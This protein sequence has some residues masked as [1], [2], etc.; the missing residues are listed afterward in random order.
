MQTPEARQ[1]FLHLFQQL[2]QRPVRQLAWACFGPSLIQHW[3]EGIS[4]RINPL[5]AW[6]CNWLKQLDQ[7]PSPLLHCLQALKNARLGFL[8][9]AYWQFYLEQ[10]PNVELLASNHQIH[11]QGKTLGAFDLLFIDEQQQAVHLEL[12]L[13]FYLGVSGSPSCSSSNF[14]CWLGPGQQDTLSSKYHHLSQQQLQLSQHSAAIDYLNQLGITQPPKK[15]AWMQGVLFQ[16]LGPRL[17]RADNITPHADQGLWCH[18]EQLHAWLHN[19]HTREPHA[20]PIMCHPLRPSHW[21][22]PTADSNHGLNIEQTLAYC[23]DKLACYPQPIYLLICQGNTHY[24]L[25]VCPNHWLS[26]ARQV[27]ANHLC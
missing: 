21:L 26:R 15:Q 17:R 11:Q 12:A 1:E 22:A 16:P 3:P 18:L 9:E 27:S 6:A 25:F 8:F 20:H 13:K 24:P 4:N 19:T 7:N 10:N 14:G 2:Q 23:S 5:S